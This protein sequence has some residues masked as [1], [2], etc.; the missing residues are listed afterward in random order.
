MEVIT[1]NQCLKGAWRD[2]ARAAR[3]M[4]IVFILAFLLVLLTSL[5]ANHVQMSAPDSAGAL[6][7]AMSA[8]ALAGAHAGAVSH[9]LA[10][11]GVTL[12][13]SLVIAGL[14][15]QVIRF[16]MTA[17]SAAQALPD[18][19]PVVA[20]ATRLFDA[21]FRRYF[22]LCLLLAGCYIGAAIAVMLIWIVVRLGGLPG[23]TANAVAATAAVLAVCGVSYVT[24][25]LALL[26]P[27]VA[28]G[29]GLQWRGAW[30][31]TR[32]HFWAIST[33]A[34]A[35]ILPVLAV[36]VVFA[37]VAEALATTSSLGDMSW[38]MVIVQSVVTL[39]YTATTATCSVWLYR[40]YATVLKTM[41]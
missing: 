40:R 2:A 26:F 14:A 18:A 11:L 27:F 6:G 21:G 5:A 30:Q 34:V 22:L 4:P 8:T 31:D 37:I 9:L 24:A 15:V 16:T 28:A 25:R 38:P 41:V 20:P 39:F 3:N 35:A 23:G 29:G 10:S 1:L 33:T 17:D 7:T 13:Q 36:A 12:L 19:Q 32:G